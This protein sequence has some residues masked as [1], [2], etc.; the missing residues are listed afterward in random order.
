MTALSAPARVIVTTFLLASLMLSGCAGPHHGFP[1]QA[2]DTDA[3]MRAFEEHFDFTALMDA[4]YSE[5]DGTRRRL[6]RNEIIQGR[7]LLIDLQ[8]AKFV[9][10]FSG[11]RKDFD[12][13]ADVTVL[14][15]NTA[16]A[17]FTPAGTVRIL[18]GAAAAVTGSRLAVDNNYFYE[19][20]IPVLIGAMN[21]Q[22]ATVRARIEESIG[23]DDDAYSLL[24]AWSDSIDYYLAGTFDG[25][26]Q[27]IQTQSA[28]QKQEAE[29]RINVIRTNA[30]ATELRQRLQGYF[31]G[32]PE[33][34]QV[35]FMQGVGRIAKDQF[36]YVGQ[37]TGFI[38]NATREQLEE[39]IR[40]LTI[41][42]S[43]QSNP[44]SQIQ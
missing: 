32:L 35:V 5:T 39:V 37:A 10:E 12:T 30:D 16:G 9:Q 7:V 33:D 8:Y 3:Q 31:L 38:Q 27:S 19:K 41:P 44:R 13:T 11:S 21:A 36:T 26:L 6:L 20:T 1:D 17:L 25:A 40:Q 14:G 24:Q 15:L 29:A 22:R 28:Q 23:K 2:M 18:S 4:Y 43:V 34:E 42:I